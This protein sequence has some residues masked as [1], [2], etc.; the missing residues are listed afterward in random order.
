MKGFFLH[1][2]FEACEGIERNTLGGLV[3]GNQVIEDTKWCEKFL[4]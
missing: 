3:L 1:W 2:C 4:P